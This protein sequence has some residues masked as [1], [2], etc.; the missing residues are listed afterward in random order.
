MLLKLKGCETE[1][2]R[3]GQ[4]VCNKRITEN[5]TNGVGNYRCC[6]CRLCQQEFMDLLIMDFD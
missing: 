3:Q 2:R 6:F 5:G 4:T 1:E